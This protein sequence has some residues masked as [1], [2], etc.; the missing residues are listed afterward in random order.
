MTPPE[1][2]MEG[3]FRGESGR[4]I[5]VLTR[6]PGGEGR[7]IPLDR[8]ERSLWDAALIA[9]GFAYLARSSRM[10]RMQAG[11]YHLEAAIAA[12]PH[13]PAVSVLANLYTRA[14][15]LEAARRFLEEALA[16]APTEHERRLIERQFDAATGGR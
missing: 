4:L 8:Q 13:G 16:G 3:L 7:L 1:T 2:D 11:A 10:D 6:R 15:S 5:A 12:P 9:R 14:G